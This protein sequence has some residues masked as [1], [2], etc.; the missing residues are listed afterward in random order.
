M[1]DYPELSEIEVADLK[2]KI[3]ELEAKV[4]KYEE[5]LEDNDL[6]EEP[7]TLSIEELICLNEIDKL[8]IVSD[9]GC[10]T[11]EDT[12]IFDLLVKNLLA[13]RGKAPVKEDNK[14]KV[15]GP[16]QVADLLKIVN[17]DKK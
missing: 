4:K 3:F 17:G 13:I 1:K 11:L 8:K 12:K 6:L 7:K 16:V 2:K 14:K 10:F 9:K 15:K 5:I